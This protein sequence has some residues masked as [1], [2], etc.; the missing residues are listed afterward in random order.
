MQTRLII[1]FTQQWTSRSQIWNQRSLQWDLKQTALQKSPLIQLCL[2]LCHR[3]KTNPKNLV[4]SP[5]KQQ[6]VRVLGRKR[7]HMQQKCKHVK[8]WNNMKFV[9]SWIS[10]WKSSKI[11]IIWRLYPPLYLDD[12]YLLFSPLFLSNSTGEPTYIYFFT[13]RA[14]TK[15]QLRGKAPR[16][17]NGGGFRAGWSIQ[18]AT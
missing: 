14:S 16:W 13:Y 11:A 18:P 7:W 10:N 2:M 15:V 17:A 1:H 4:V 9:L 3:R 12:K 8:S 6:W 5:I